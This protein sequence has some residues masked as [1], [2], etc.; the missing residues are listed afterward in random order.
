M[1]HYVRDMFS[2]LSIVR[3]RHKSCRR[4]KPARVFVK[5]C[6]PSDS[7]AG[8]L[9]CSCP[10]GLAL[11]DLG[12]NSI[13]RSA[14]NRKLL[15]DNRQLA[16]DNLIHYRRPFISHRHDDVGDE[17]RRIVD[18][19]DSFHTPIDAGRQ[20]IPAPFV[21]VEA[22]YIGLAVYIKSQ[23]MFLLPCN[24]SCQLPAASFQLKPNP[25]SS[26]VSPQMHPSN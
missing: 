6:L 18:Y 2:Q 10:S 14:R 19:W 9:N 16:T 13:P 23:F 24:E 5:S 8:L 12:S 1:D 20:Q 4:L 17:A 3:P 22:Q 15:S 26:E 25:L 21:G 7:R 11:I